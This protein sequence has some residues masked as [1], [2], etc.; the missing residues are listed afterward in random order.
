MVKH[1]LT[2][3]VIT[4]LAFISNC[5][6]AQDVNTV[7]IKGG[8]TI[9]ISSENGLRAIHTKTGEDVEFRVMTAVKVNGVT[10][11]PY[12]S[13]VIG[14][15]LKAKR[16]KIFG[17]KGK[18]SIQLNYIILP[19]GERVPLS[20]KTLNFDGDS[21]VAWVVP[22]GVLVCWPILFVTGEKAK[23]EA[24][25]TTTVTVAADTDIDIQK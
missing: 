17:I 3:F 23:M 6:F 10:A 22:V 2:F 18:L 5:I 21:R 20:S 4:L 8:T 1:A 7:T 9:Q 14:N 16:S 12:N 25:Y 24:G 19:S 13:L 15:V 11:I